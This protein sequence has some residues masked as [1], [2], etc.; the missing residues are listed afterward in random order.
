MPF[1]FAHPAIIL[2]L[3][4]KTGN[5]F[6]ATGLIMGSIIPDFEYF[7][8]LSSTSVVTHTLKGILIVDVPAAIVLSICFHWFIKQPLIANLHP[9]IKKYFLHVTEVDWMQYFKKSFPVVVISC[10]IG[11]ALHVAWDSI[12]HASGY[13]ASQYS[14]LQQTVFLNSLPYYRLI[15]WLSTVGGS[16][17][18][19]YFIKNY[20]PSHSNSKENNPHNNYWGIV[21]LL[22]CVILVFD[23]QSFYKPHT[24]RNLFTAITGSFLFSIIF[25][26]ALFRLKKIY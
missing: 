21:F 8:N 12:S 22:M 14:F 1:T 6:S 10:L 20:L 18:V 2:P 9:S 15:W 13:F 25:T 5:Y 17:Y 7:F 11:S 3:I 26:S 16:L 24:L 4:K 19:I 23:W